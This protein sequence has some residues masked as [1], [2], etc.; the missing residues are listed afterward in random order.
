MNKKFAKRVIFV[1][2][3]LWLSYKLAGGFYA[4]KMIFSLTVVCAVLVSAYA[5][6]LCVWCAVIRRYSD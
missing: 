6:V 1:G 3:W 5:T 4:E 2:L